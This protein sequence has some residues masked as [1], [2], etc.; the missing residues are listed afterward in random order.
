MSECCHSLC[1]RK[2]EAK[3]IGKKASKSE[4]KVTNIF[5]VM[6]N[7]NVIKKWQRKKVSGLP[8][9]ASTLFCGTL[10]SRLCCSGRCVADYASS[11][12]DT[13]NP[14]RWWPT[15]H[16]WK[17]FKGW[18]TSDFSVRGQ[19]GGWPQKLEPWECLAV[20]ART[21]PGTQRTLSRGS[22]IKMNSNRDRMQSAKVQNLVTMGWAS[23]RKQYHWMSFRNFPRNNGMSSGAS[24]SVAW[25][26]WSSQR[27]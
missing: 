21:E 13:Q 11:Q 25:I 8:P 6:N 27:L 23:T 19:G 3:G 22:R 10:V 2:R 24:S 7:E 26:G 9:F 12:E 15:L 4:K 18:A 20:V 17:D 1:R 5:K 14:S 16:S